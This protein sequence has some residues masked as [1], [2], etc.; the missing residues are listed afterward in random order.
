MSTTRTTIE[1]D[2][3]LILTAMRL[4]GTRTKKE[5]VDLALRPEEALALARVP[6]ADRCTW[7][8]SVAAEPSSARTG[9]SWMVMARSVGGVRGTAD[10][11]FHRESETRSRIAAPARDAAR[12]DDRMTRGSERRPRTGSHPTPAAGAGSAP[13]PPRT[14]RR[15]SDPP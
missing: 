5:T 2:D 11:P 3:E 7:S 9:V 1:L 4:H 10:R 6:E 8:S 12:P 13:S 14:R 15:A